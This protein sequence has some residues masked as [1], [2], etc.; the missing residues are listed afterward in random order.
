MVST[1]S[2]NYEILVGFLASLIFGFRTSLLDSYVT[3]RFSLFLG[4]F[5]GKSLHENF[6]FWWQYAQL[7]IKYVD[8]LFLGILIQIFVDNCL[9]F[10]PFSFGHCIVCPFLISGFWLFQS[11]DDHGRSCTIYNYIIYT[12]NITYM[13]CCLHFCGLYDNL[14]SLY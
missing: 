4:P 12:Y 13:I 2:F 1:I 8:T 11:C 5:W 7:N 14:L 6:L 9:S 3:F 10:C